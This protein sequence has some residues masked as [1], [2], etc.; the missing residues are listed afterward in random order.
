MNE[1]IA[2]LRGNAGVADC[3]DAADTIERMEKRIEELER[4]YAKCD[5]LVS[6]QGIR[7]MEEEQR[8]EKAEAATAT[9]KAAATDAQFALR[10]CLQHADK[11]ATTLM[12][13]GV[14]DMCVEQCPQC[15]YYT[16]RAKQ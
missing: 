1:L 8:A 4:E 3:L 16:W 11:M 2:R 15:S 12:D 5:R 10:E 14:C 13:G 6:S 7:L 9:F